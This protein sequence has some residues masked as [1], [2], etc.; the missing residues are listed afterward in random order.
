M[1]WGKELRDHLSLNSL[2]PKVQRFL[3]RTSRS[4]SSG[5]Q[6][7][8]LWHLA[9]EHKEHQEPAQMFTLPLCSSSFP[10]TQEGCAG[11]CPSSGRPE[12]TQ[13]QKQGQVNREGLKRQE[14][15]RCPDIKNTFFLFFFKHVVSQVLRVMRHY[16][17]ILHAFHKYPF[18]LL[19]YRF[20]S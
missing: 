18:L 11:D 15:W 7:T 3:P 2:H 1:S 13:R 19:T 20:N 14:I 4:L 12:V 9:G 5:P 10:A 17:I 16:L 6:V 8:Q